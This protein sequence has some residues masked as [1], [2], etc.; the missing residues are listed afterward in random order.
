MM[1]VTSQPQPR[2]QQISAEQENYE[3]LVYAAIKPQWEQQVSLKG[4]L[5]DIGT[6]RVSFFVRADGHAEV[7]K[8]LSNTSN[9]ALVMV[10]IASLRR[11]HIPPIPESL[12]KHLPNRRLDLEIPFTLNPN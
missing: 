2:T 7:V 11:A 6:V 1:A 8:I 3:K 4:D 10:V 5:V 12:L 9:E